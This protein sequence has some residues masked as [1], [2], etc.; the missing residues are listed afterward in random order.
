MGPQIL[1]FLPALMLGAYWYGGEG[2][3]MYM[4]LLFPGLFAL[5]GLFSKAANGP[6]AFDGITGLKLRAAAI[7]TLDR[8]LKTEPE[9]GMAT[10]A[11]VVALDDFQTIDRQFGAKAKAA[12]LSQTAQRLQ[13]ALR[14]TDLVVCLGDAIYGIALAPTRRSDLETLIQ[15]S[16]RLQATIAEP[17]S[18]DATRVYITISIGFCSSGRLSVKSGDV[19]LK[20]AEDALGAA[21]VNG[22]GSIRAYSAE[23]KRKADARHA[24]RE[25]V[26]HALESGQ[27]LP[28]FQPQVSTDTGE[29]TGFEA[30][31]RWEHPENGVILQSDFQGAISELN[32]AERLSEIMLYQSLNALRGWE[33]A[34][35]AIPAVSVNFSKR[36]LENPKL[37]EKIR[38]E[39][40]RFQL[41]PERLCVEIREDVIAGPAD[42]TITRNIWALSEFGCNI[43]LGKFGSGHA[44][45]SDIRRFAVSRVKI[46]KSFVTHVDRDREQ[47]NMVAAVLTMAERLEIDTL[48]EGVETVGE[49]AMLSQLGCGH[50]QGFSVARPIPFE[51]TLEWIVQHHAKQPKTFAI[52]RKSG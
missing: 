19:M 7:Q 11:V 14:D 45:I 1:A 17:F 43:D 48:A 51:A 49:H 28:W 29:I 4:A 2:L 9:T 41:A 15:L 35:Q 38:W 25:D 34:S 36:E 30:L 10:A 40:D 23:T 50:V 20:N 26:G 52:G 46:D 21:I 31:A 39:L 13:S 3:L 18:I 22:A 33:K 12:I 32:L 5:A 6:D 44:S 16:A 8:H 47:Q 24:L 27:I 37:C 42:D